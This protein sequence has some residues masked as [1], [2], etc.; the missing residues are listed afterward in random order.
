MLSPE[1]PLQ[2]QAHVSAVVDAAASSNMTP[3][4]AP[5]CS[6]GCKLR[7]ELTDPEAWRL[8]W[9]VAEWDVE[10][11]ASRLQRLPSQVQPQACVFLDGDPCS[12]HSIRPAA[13]LPLNRRLALQCRVLVTCMLQ[14]CTGQGL[15]ALRNPLSKAVLAALNAL[16][17]AQ[18]WFVG[19]PL[20][21][22]QT[23]RA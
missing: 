9:H 23:G 8:D 1:E 3:A 10:S 19:Q 11:R 17:T 4:G 13:E 14:A 5:G 21:A 22:P 18:A 6:H 12:V 15:Q 16:D 20:I 2:V 7:V